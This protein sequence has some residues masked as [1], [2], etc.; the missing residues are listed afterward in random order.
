MFD[1]EVDVIVVEECVKKGIMLCMFID[2]EILC[3]Y[4][5]VM[6]NEG[7]NVV[8]EK[9]VLCLFDVDVV[10]LY[11]YG[12][13][14]YCGGL[15]YYVDMFGFVNVFVDI[16]MFVKDDLLFWKLLLLFVDFVVCGVD[17]VSLNYID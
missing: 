3:C 14:C 15:M 17:F 16:C 11:G 7:V 8:Y 2:D 6:I 4:F 1:L 5:V 9:I 13:L 10:F 12:F